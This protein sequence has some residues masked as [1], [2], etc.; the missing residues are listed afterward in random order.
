MVQQTP[1]M[2]WNSWNTF[3]SNVSEQLIFEMADT[4]VKGGFLDAG[5]NYLV[6]DDCWA[7]KERDS[8]GRLVPNHEKFSHGMKAVADYVHS[9]GLKFGMYSC[10]GVRTCANYPSSFEREF[11]DAQTFAS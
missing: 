3:G 8:E 4:M 10:C 1:P 7:E 2:G 9:K 5:Y 6:I 11:V